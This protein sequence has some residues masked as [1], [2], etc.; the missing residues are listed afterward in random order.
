ML[1]LSQLLQVPQ[2]DTAFDIAPD[3]S[4]VAFSWNKTGDWQ[5]Y[6]LMLDSGDSRQLTES[7]GAKF[8]PHY[9]P[10]GSQLAY[11]VD[12]DGGENFLC[13]SAKHC[14]VAGWT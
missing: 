2:V 5:L 9:S 3:G 7:A 4:R 8:S 6:E 11:V 13:A 1:D 10:D 14:L 12:F